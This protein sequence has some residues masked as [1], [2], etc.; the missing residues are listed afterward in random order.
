MKGSNNRK[1]I[2]SLFLR[3]VILWL[4]LVVMQ[5]SLFA[6][7][8]EDRFSAIE[9]KLTAL[10]NGDSPGLNEKVELSVNGVSIQEFIRG[11]AVQNNLNI[12]V[13]PSLNISVVNNF[14]NLPVEDVLLFLCKNYNL[15]INFIGSIMSVIKYV[16]PVVEKIVS[17]PKKLKISYDEN[18]DELS[19]DL[20]ND[21]LQA[22]A[23]EITRLSKKNV[24]YSADIANKLVNGFIQ[25]TSFASALYNLALTNDLKATLTED[26]F[27]LIEKKDVVGLDKTG[28]GA[29]NGKGRSAP[30]SGLKLKVDENGLLNIEAI[31]VPIAEV[32]D[33]VCSEFKA[34]Y[35]MF[36]E[37][38]GNIT[39][40]IT[41]SGLEEF[42]KKIFNGT[43][44][45]FQK[46]DGIYLIGERSQ[47][48][49]RTS[50]VL[51]FKYRT[52]DKVIDFIPADLKKGLEL[53]PFPD[54]NSLIMSG[55]QPR[56][57]ELESFLRDI[58]RVVPVVMLELTVVD[59]TDTKTLATGISAG[60]GTAP[61]VTGG[62][63]F[64]GPNV[65]LSST[66]IN[67]LI[68]GL[69]GGLINLGS[70]TPNFYLNLQALESQGLIKI[71]ST[72]KLATLNGH[73]AKMTIGDTEYYLQTS[74]TLT[75]SVAATT[76]TAQSWLPVNADLEI[77]VNPMVSADNQIT[78]D[79]K[80]K[81]STFT[82]RIAPTAPPGTTTRNFQSL[83]RVKNNETILLG[84][85]EENQVNDSGSGFPFL[86]RIPIIKW[87]FSSRTK[88]NTKA[89]LSIFIKPTV[90]Y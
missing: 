87:F 11:L 61:A 15:D 84:G 41:G 2:V 14:T 66:S 86:S 49:L 22:V 35:F 79:V 83:I 10:A 3:V 63:V 57:D 47:E 64:P 85:L 23:R 88:T 75:G 68:S 80:F 43:E 32:V 29:K 58:D 27:Y 59:V 19:M 76:Q 62:Q 45:T 78:L 89:R 50:K 24:I 28:K 34:N 54:L 8:A 9:Q 65:T 17:G 6:Q 12:T 37:L 77:S 16:P 51:Q 13:D 70:V 21:S 44:Y 20:S 55:S 81:Q 74:T 39:L 82:A 7:Q 56:M 48:G 60:L 46:R 1:K 73:E 71:R 18:S 31:A 38:K 52:V 53:K 26:N 30:S 69:T 42:L 4:F 90:M 67:N 25:E 40:N 36:S 5:S 33:Q 72:P